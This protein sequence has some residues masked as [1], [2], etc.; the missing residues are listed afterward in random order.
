MRADVAIVGNGPTARLAAL[1]LGNAGLDVVLVGPEADRSADPRTTALMPSSVAALERLGIDVAARATALTELVIETTGPF[2]TVSERFSAGEAGEEFLAL[3]LF[4]AD[5]LQ[6][7]PFRGRALRSEMTGLDFEAGSNIVHAADGGR[8]AARL[9]VAADGFGSR[10]R[11]LAGIPMLRRDLGRSAYCVAVGLERPHEG[12][13]RERYDGRG[14][15]TVIPVGERSASLISIGSPAAVAAL[16]AGRREAAERSLAERQPG[17]GVIALE[18]D[19]AVFPLAIGWAAAPAR[20]RVV[21]VGEAAHIAPP[22][23]AQGWNMA[24]QDVTALCEALRPAA[25]A[26]LDIG[27]DDTLARYSAAR[28]PDLAGR[29]S[30]IGLLAGLATRPA[31]P[32]RLARQAGLLALS[33][34]PGAKRRLMRAGLR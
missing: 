29:L 3:N 14:T 32:L 25:A 30:A 15:V 19:P 17:Y 21:A 28:R 31:G 5:L 16:A 8:V 6:L 2:G 23:G 33:R 27:G 13:C 1:A 12:L 24:V 4:I 7:M 10:T 20:R 11:E 22:I 9:V 34:L 26:G 18:G